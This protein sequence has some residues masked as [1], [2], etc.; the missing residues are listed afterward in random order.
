M[1][2]DDV[3]VAEVRAWLVRAAS[4]LRAA[5]HDFAAVPPLLDDAVFHC[6][7]VVE[8]TFK[9]YLAW[10]DR[11]FRKTHSLEE[12]G[13]ACIP[14]DNALRTLVDAAVPL[15][16]YAWKFRYPGEVE[17][18]TRQEAEVALAV[19]RT[20]FDAIRSRLPEAAHP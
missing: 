3:R 12:L 8:K 11:P 20:I 10:H 6:Q 15:T 2:G 7:Q 19:A 1:Q 16:E 17:R 9:A 14:L 18:P 13:E 5:E 4:D